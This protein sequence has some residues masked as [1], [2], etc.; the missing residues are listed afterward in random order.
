[1]KKLIVISLILCL[2]FALTSA[3]GF[4]QSEGG[5][6]LINPVFQD[7]VTVSTDDELILHIGWGACT[8][9]LVRAYI[10]AAHYQWSLG[11]DPILPHE[12]TAQYFGPIHRVGAV[13]GCL[14]GDGTLW[15]SYWDYSIGN[16]SPGTYEIRLLRWLAHPVI[17]GGDWDGDGRIDFFEGEM[18][19]DT[20]TVYV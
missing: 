16:L 20:I 10:T 14:A 11:G 18:G 1:M 2:A 8:R 6:V 15:R 7:E 4:A 12:E 9:G 13:D 19:D 17:D 3:T 5:S